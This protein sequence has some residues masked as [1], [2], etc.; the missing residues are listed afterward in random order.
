MAT[1]KLSKA[2]DKAKKATSRKARNKDLR[3]KAAVA[4]DKTIKAKHPGKRKSASGAT[5]F[6]SRP[7]RSDVNRTKKFDEGG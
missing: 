4:A 6:E 3:T 5:Y 2:L 7:N 1:N